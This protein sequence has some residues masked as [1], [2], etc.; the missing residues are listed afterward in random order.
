MYIDYHFVTGVRKE[1]KGHYFLFLI[2]LPYRGG[3]TLFLF[4]IYLEGH[5]RMLMLLIHD[6][7]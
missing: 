1:I 4:L 7:E 6:D 3:K 2:F 5:T